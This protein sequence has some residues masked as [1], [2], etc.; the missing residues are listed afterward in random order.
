MARNKKQSSTD[1]NKLDIRRIKDDEWDDFED[2]YID[3]VNDIQVPVDLGPRDILRINAEVDDV[4]TE[5]RFD[6]GFAKSELAYWEQRLSNAKKNSKLVFK[7]EKGQT[8]ED[9][10]A[11]ITTFLETKPLQGDKEPVYILVNR[12]SKRALFMESVIDNLLK[13]ADKMISGNGAL[14]LDA[15][16]RGDT[17]R[18]KR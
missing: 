3:K 16:G 6:Y 10:D 9:R 15:Q 12:W 13:K 17:G 2:Y 8:N 18:D 11:I 14:K 4:Y 5:A 1:P 7:K